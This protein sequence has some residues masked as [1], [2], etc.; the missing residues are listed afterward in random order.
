VRPD[1]VD[2]FFVADPARP[3]IAD[4]LCTLAA[5]LSDGPSVRL[6]AVDAPGSAVRL[7]GGATTFENAEKF[8]YT[9][10]LDL[11]DRVDAGPPPWAGRLVRDV[12]LRG[13][14]LYPML[15]KQDTWSLR[16]NGLEVGQ[17]TPTEGRFDVGRD[18][19]NGPGPQRSAFLAATG[20]GGPVTCGPEGPFDRV[21]EVLRNFAERWHGTAVRGKYR[22][23]QNEHALESRILEGAV[24][25]RVDGVPLQRLEPEAEDLVNWGSQ[26]PTGWG[27][28]PGGDDRRRASGA[29]YL[30]ALLRNDRTPWAV[31]MKVA[32]GAGVG[33]YYRHA[34]A[35]A[36]LYRQFI[37]TAEPLR[38]WFEKHRLDQHACRAAVVVPSFLPRQEKWRPRLERVCAAFGVELV[39][40]DSADATAGALG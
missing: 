19:T 37:Q 26:F 14:R 25:L 3:E 27:R 36:V 28:R 7:D 22:D 1:E 29:R 33:Q 34:V 16:L 20:D 4:A 13:L 40:V 6:L 23:R 39:V 38:P 8:Q 18:G 11:L 31:E 32:G 21:V 10:W 24:T 30:D 35:Q 12:G 17:C 5:S 2:V 9:G 15:S